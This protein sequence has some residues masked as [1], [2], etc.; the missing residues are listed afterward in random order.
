MT[1]GQQELIGELRRRFPLLE[2]IVGQFGEETP[3]ERIP[4]FFGLLLAAAVKPGTG[5][6][7]FVLDKTL[8][9]T[10]ITATLT[11][12]VRLRNDLP[13]LIENYL[14]SLSRGQRVKVLPGGSVYEYEGPWID[15]PGHF[16]LKL[17]GRD[18]WRTF[19]RWKT[20]SDWSQLIMYGQRAPVATWVRPNP[21]HSTICSITGFVAISAS[22]RT[23][24]LFTC[25]EAVSGESR[26][27]L[28]SG[29]EVINHS[30]GSPV[31]CPGVSLDETAP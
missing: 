5:P 22:S 3:Y 31:S 24:C 15:Y 18:A 7:C 30:P 12:L 29:R 21:V 16:R 25:R 17:L 13:G 10:P 2:R 6:C 14:N 9:T 11:A 20:C 28:L 27:Q 26:S 19:F 1:D 23:R 8:G 4:W